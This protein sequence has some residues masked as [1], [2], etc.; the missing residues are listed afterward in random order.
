[1]KRQNTLLSLIVA[2]ASMNANAELAAV[3]TPDPVTGFPAYYQ[4]YGDLNSA[5]PEPL[6]LDLCLPNKVPFDTAELADGS[7]LM[8][9]GD[10]TIPDESQPI[11][12]PD[13]FPDEAF[14][15]NASAGMTLNGGGNAKL[16]LAVEAAF[17]NAVQAGD[18]IVF[19]RLRYLFTAPLAGFYTIETP[20]STDGPEHKSAGQEVKFN[21]DVGVNCGQGVFTCALAG[22]TAPFLRPSDTSGDAPKPLYEAHGNKYLAQ[23]GINTRVTGAPNGKNW[24]RILFQPDL[25]TPPTVMGFTDQF[26]V[27]GRLYD[28]SVP[29]PIPPSKPKLPSVV[30]AAPVAQIA[31]VATPKVSISAVD[32]LAS[33]ATGDPGK[34][35][36]NLNAPSAK[37]IKVKYSVEGTAKIGKDYRKFSSSL[38]IPAGSVF[39]AIDVWP[40]ND[41]EN[42]RTEKVTLKLSNK[43]IK[44]YTVKGRAAANIKIL[45]DD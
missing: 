38:V 18:Q 7:C 31:T 45:D 20:Y 1:M 24:F 39:G 3:G 42:E 34:F 13:N 2:I 26:Q 23:P 22:P 36:I 16:V 5:N 17:T 14:Y 12:F 44:G 9:S 8:L 19:S 30:A 41:N 11:S 15:Y 27:M 6:A 35:M 28:G 25:L 29:K 33:E 4:D 37:N 43:G 10:G 21:E 32:P 40:L